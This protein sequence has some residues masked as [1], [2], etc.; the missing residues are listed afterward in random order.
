MKINKLKK[1]VLALFVIGVIII[2]FL[3]TNLNGKREDEEYEIINNI[4]D[5]ALNSNETIMVYVGGVSCE[6]CALQSY[7]MKLF[8]KEYDLEYYYINLEGISKSDSKKILKKLNLSEDVSLPTIAIYENGKLTT[9][10]SGLVGTNSLYNL[11]KNH[12]LIAEKPLNMNYLTITKY[13]EKIESGSF[14]LAVGSMKSKESMKFEEILWQVIDEYNID[15]NFIYVS[16]LNKL[17]GEL[18]ESKLKNFNEYDV[19][20]PTLLLVSDGKIEN[21]LIGLFEKENYVEFLR[22]NDIIK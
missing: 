1:I 2:L 14:V 4:A 18:F 6:E 9:S 7:Q 11:L 17:E 3:I 13:V 21:A 22:E 5:L 20:I 10:Q 15:L 19:S 12:G 16:N 8:L